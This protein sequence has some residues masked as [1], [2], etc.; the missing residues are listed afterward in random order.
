MND[1]QKKLGFELKVVLEQELSLL[2]GLLETL[3][4][5]R[6]LLV[7]FRP[8]QLLEQNKRKEI[9]VLQHGY[10]EQ[11]RRDLSLSLTASL[12]VDGVEL[13]LREIAERLGG[14]LGR[15]LMDL[16]DSLAALTDAIQEA[17]ELN[18]RLTEFS[19]RSVKS[20]VSFLKSRFFNSDTYSAGGTLRNDLAQLSVINSRA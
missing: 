9:L 19:I 16:R 15:K 11:N 20:S 12:G 17:N 10:L 14:E 7:Q 13:P 4:G 18:K 1:L 5:E 6:E 3:H 2:D 8:D